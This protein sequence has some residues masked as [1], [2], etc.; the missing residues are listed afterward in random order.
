VIVLPEKVGVVTDGD[1]GDA[2]GLF[3]GLAERTGAT[4][5]VGLIQVSGG[6]KYNRARVYAPGVAVRT[7]DKQHMLPPFESDLRPGTALTLMTKGGERWGVEICKDMDFTPLAREY[8]QAGAGMMLVPAWDFRLDRWWHG[9][10]AVMRG[11]E[12]GFSVA[13]ASRDG[14]LTVSDDRGRILAETRSDSAT[15]ATLMA[16]A[17]AGHEATVFQAL[18]DWFAWIAMGGLALSCWRAA[19]RDR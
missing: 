8:G 6:T 19:R 16:E 13:R 3:Q 4:I 14:N 7:Y 9:H 15:V 18:G 5:V 1:V 17:P 11:V 2:D 10:I 12:D